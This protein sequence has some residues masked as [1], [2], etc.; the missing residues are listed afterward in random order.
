[1][2]PYPTIMNLHRLNLNT[3]TNHHAMGVLCISKYST[4]YVNGP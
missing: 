4:E 3:R 2:K 1:M